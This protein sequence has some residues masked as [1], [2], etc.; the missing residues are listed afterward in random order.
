MRSVSRP[1]NELSAKIRQLLRAD[2]DGRLW[3]LVRGSKRRVDAPAGCLKRDGYVYVKVDHVEL[4]AHRVVWFLKH[5]E[6]PARF[7]DHI[8]GNR[9]NNSPSNLRLADSQQN[10]RNSAVRVTNTSGMP[11]VHL[12]KDKGLWQA[13]VWLNGKPK[14]LGY[15]KTYDLA[16]SARLEAERSAYGEYSRIESRGG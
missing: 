14:S 1:S 3:W 8:D 12:H 6:W 4:L 15:F 16:C 5:G 2:E 9:S 11:G 10:S 13:R 7:I